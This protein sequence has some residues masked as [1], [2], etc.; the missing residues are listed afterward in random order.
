[1]TA[2][3]KQGNL[4]TIMADASK[5][6][7]GPDHAAPYPVSRLAPAIDLVDLAREIAEADRLL[8]TR[9]SAKLQV[10][11][12]QIRSLQ[13]EARAVLAEAKRDQDLNHVA[14]NFAKKPGGIYHLY[15]RS[16][17]TRYFSMLSP[18]DW[19]G[20]PPHSF[21]GAYRLEADHSWTPAEEMDRPDE[22]HEL[23]RRLLGRE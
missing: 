12:D 17:G 22:S 11:A 1:M 4:K 5:K 7:H 14:C 20:M 16:D 19:Q 3:T 15:S 8:N 10:I 23:V 2:R 18:D 6:H 9:I 13:E 21:L